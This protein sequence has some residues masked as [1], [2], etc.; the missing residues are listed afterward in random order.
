[1]KRLTTFRESI[2]YPIAGATTLLFV[3]VA[4]LAHYLT[5]NSI[6]QSFRERSHAI[7]SLFA[8]NIRQD[9]LVG[10]YPE[11]YRKCRNLVDSGSVIFVH[12]T[13]SNG[14]DVCKLG[15]EELSENALS[16]STDI[17]FDLAQSERA[18]RIQMS[19]STQVLSHVK[20][21][22]LFS[23]FAGLLAF[24]LILIFLINRIS[25]KTSFPVT[26]LS[27]ALKKGDLESLSTLKNPSSSNS[28]VE[29][30]VL[31]R[32]TELLARRLLKSQEELLQR[33]AHEVQENIARQVAHDIRSPLAA[34]EMLIKHSDA[35]PEGVRNLTRDATKRIRD[36]ANNLLTSKKAGSVF[37]GASH[38]VSVQKVAPLVDSIVH[39]K[40]AEYMN[41]KDVALNWVA[42]EEARQLECQLDSVSFKRVLSNLI[43][44]AFESIEGPGR[45][46]VSLKQEGARARL[47]V[48]DSG[49]GIA[50]EVLARV[51]EKGFSFGKSG[52]SGLGL[53]NA[54]EF[55]ERF[56]GILGVDSSQGIGTSITVE[57]PVAK[58]L[59]E[60]G[61]QSEAGMR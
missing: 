14:M 3:L 19:Y 54:K 22:V 21:Q 5:S 51:G 8:D 45:I 42:T 47:V 57:F 52:G 1:M 9:I 23:L 20:R 4:L 38:V 56:G 41:R 24:F 48:R 29:T 36:I 2:F 7:Q 37:D 28:V 53:F 12:V 27:E 35:L 34:L 18:A 25:K 61:L 30:K 59:Q 10:S 6:D 58:T 16:E 44:N 40:R 50:P 17:Y 13:S 46:V 60:H 43:N 15:K 31:F 39:E 11:V 26:F 55:V 33:R 32:E 49:K